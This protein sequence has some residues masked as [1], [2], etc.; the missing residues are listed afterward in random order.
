MRRIVPL[1]FFLIVCLLGGSVAESTELYREETTVL[2][3]PEYDIPATVCLP[4]GEG[5]FPA[6]VMLPSTGSTR[7]EA[8]DAY[9]YAAHTL[10][11][12]YGIASIRIDFPGNGESI[13]DYKSYTLHSAVGDA[14]AAAQYMEQLDVI[15]EDRI[16]VLG[17][18]QGGTDALLACA[19]EPE[20][21]KA[22]VTWA[23]AP[24]MRIDGFFS[25]KNYE[26][27][28]ENGFYVM[29]FD[30]RDSLEVSLEWCE[31][32]MNTDVIEEFRTKFFGPVL[33]IHGQEDSTVDSEW[34]TKVVEA[35]SN[36]D[37]KTLLIDGMDHTFNVLS[38]DFSALF[39]AVDATGEFFVLVL[40]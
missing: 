4:I 5:P 38:G 37:S 8:G 2:L 13:A 28:K 21:F 31:D 15:D 35:S 30:W 25:A 26:E 20:T 22:V 33:A 1:F 24:D 36:I 16:G 6:I 11:S 14:K 3:P 27:A 7:D 12:Q 39:T 23:A 29:E 40:N 18:G 34:S 10:A 19:W 32:V 9:M 17:W